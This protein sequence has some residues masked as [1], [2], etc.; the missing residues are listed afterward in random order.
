MTDT[1]SGVKVF[2]AV[3]IFVI[4]VF[5]RLSTGAWNLWGYSPIMPTVP[6]IGTGLV[7]LLQWVIIPPLV[8]W[9]VRRQLI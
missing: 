1:H 4:I 5:E 9:F 2:L 6:I 8:I 7:P 3:G